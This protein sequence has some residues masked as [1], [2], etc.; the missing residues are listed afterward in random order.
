MNKPVIIKDI[1]QG[2]EAWHELRAGIPTASDFDKII[3]SQGKKSTQSQ[4]YMY[5]LVAESIIGNYDNYTNENMQ[6]G[7]ELEEL[8]RTEYEL[9]TG[10]G[11]EQV[12]FVYFDNKKDFGCSPDGLINKGIDGNAGGVEIKCPLPHTHISYVLGKKVPT[13]YVVQVQGNMLVT[14]R[15]WWDFFSYC[16]GLPNYRITVFRD[17]EFIKIMLDYLKLFVADLKMYKNSM[18]E[19][20]K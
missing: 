7:Q 13:S 18:K 5:K 14:G 16:R 9:D 12:G 6:N 17:E 1:E 8:A 11:V 19:D 4:K 3:T 10:L 20:V 15:K 2:S